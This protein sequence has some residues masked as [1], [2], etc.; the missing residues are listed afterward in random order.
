[1]HPTLKRILKESIPLLSICLILGTVG[2][3]LLNARLEHLS[4]LPVFLV[5][6]PVING[7]GGNLGCVLGARVSSGL[8][9]GTIQPK[10][11]GKE[12]KQN[13]LVYFLLGIITYTTISI[14]I[15]IGI[16]LL[17]IRTDLSFM[18]FSGVL[19]FAGGLL[20]CLVVLLVLSTAFVSFKKGLDPDN[21]VLP[22]VTSVTDLAG[23]SCLILAMGVI[24]L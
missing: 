5:F 16:P 12:L 4:L 1:M 24:G 14:F 22:L 11:K 18:K 20:V 9:L 10:L 7:V 17:G 21:T 23:I 3:Q 13:I 8:H 6:V 2:G 19:L 15:W